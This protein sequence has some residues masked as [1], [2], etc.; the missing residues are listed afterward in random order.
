MK[1]L[2]QR[3]SQPRLGEKVNR[4]QALVDWS[5]E[6]QHPHSTLHMDGGLGSCTTQRYMTMC[7]PWGEARI[8][9]HH[10]TTASWLLFLCS[11]IPLFPWRSRIAEA[12]S[13][14]RS[15]PGLDHRMALAKKSRFFY[16]KKAMPGSLSPRTSPPT[17]Q[18]IGVQMP[19]SPAFSLQSVEPHVPSPTHLWCSQMISRSLNYYY[20]EQEAKER[21]ASRSMTKMLSTS[22]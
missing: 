16:V 18:L 8:L 7:V 13:R 1:G 6:G 2:A 5:H 3:R 4:V 12:C 20:L 10:W 11:C 15:R 22:Q 9:F 21:K 14:A 17:H 19:F